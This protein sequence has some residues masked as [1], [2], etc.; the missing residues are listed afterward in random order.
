MKAGEGGRAH[1]APHMGEQFLYLLGPYEVMGVERFVR[2]FVPD[3][4]A[5]GAP[6]LFMF[7]GQNVFHDAP[8]FSGGWYA[9]HAVGAL[10]GAGQRAP[11]IIAID[12]GG[13][14][15]IHELSPFRSR[16]TRGELDGLLRWLRRDL[17]PLVR[18]RFSTSGQA[19]DNVIAGASMGGL[20]ATYALLKHPDLF[21]AA[22]AMSP[23]FWIADGAL[24][25]WASS[26][27]LGEAQRL[28]LDA[29]GDEGPYTVVEHVEW[30][31]GHLRQ[32]GAGERL[33]VVIDPEAT[34]TEPAWRA[35]LPG[36]LRH[37]FPGYA[38]V[39]LEAAG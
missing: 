16:D 2:V 17:V 10:S 8:S 33:Q 30:L 5:R 18:R 3:E 23:S 32:H 34:H 19:E 13:P 21:G 27:R 20:A 31:A 36:A 25:K 35:R 28:Y 7:D 26:R 1:L 24:L 29:G 12:H 15:R 39:E 6:A 9:H 38:P 37:V 14:G 11:V 22:I 4:R